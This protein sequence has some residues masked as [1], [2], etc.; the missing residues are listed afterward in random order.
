MTVSNRQK[1]KTYTFRNQTFHERDFVENGKITPLGVDYLREFKRFSLFDKPWS[2]VVFALSLPVIIPLVLF[3]VLSLI[4]VFGIGIFLKKNLAICLDDS[5]RIVS[6][7]YFI[8]LGIHVKSKDKEQTMP[9]QD[10]DPETG[11]LCTVIVSNH[12][13]RIDALLL[14]NLHQSD[15]TYLMSARESFF[16]KLIIDS[17]LCSR[18]MVDGLALDTKEGREEWRRRLK[19]GYRRSMLFFP[20]GRIVHPAD[21]ILTFQ[22]HLFHGQKA[23]IICKKNTYQ[24]FFFENAQIEAP[25][26]KPP[27]SRLKHKRFW[28][29]IV[30]VL[31][32]FVAWLT[33][34][35]TE[36]IGKLRFN[37][38]ETPE[39]IDH[40]LY[41]IY[42]KNGYR[43]V[44]LDPELVK[45]LMN[46]LYL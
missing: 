22:T 17:G 45:K 4:S 32:F 12:R 21:A 44:S 40:A 15:S 39:E 11:E 14:S 8:C 28:D 1:S 23:D 18:S 19:N 31:P 34:M 16:G 6:L 7:I 46:A 41:E 24:S 36:V 10:S 33:V 3:R 30:E 9:I 38:S 29:S 35:R 37:G 43:L 42:F 27:Y 20:E 5:P 13:S 26:F 25:F 2:A